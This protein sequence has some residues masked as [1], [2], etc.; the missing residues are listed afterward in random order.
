MIS[1]ADEKLTGKVAI[2]TALSQVRTSGLGE[3]P[4]ITG[5]PSV[6][7]DQTAVVMKAV[8]PRITLT[9]DP[10]KGTSEEDKD[11]S[12][13]A[14][15]PRL[16]AYKD[17][18]NYDIAVKNPDPD[19]TYRNITIEDLLP[20]EQV[21]PEKAS[22]VIYVDDDKDRAVKISKSPRASMKEGTDGKLTFT[23]G[24]FSEYVVIRE[25][26]SSVSNMGGADGP[27]EVSGKSDWLLWV[28]IPVAV[29]T[30][31]AVVVTVVLKKKK[32]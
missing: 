31:A 13:T 7:K 10:A 15:K 29:V 2:N 8:E 26:N 9:A 25:E 6:V 20:L 24:H 4:N 21:Q 16:M 22:V 11:L 1:P 14:E 12:T 5:Q 3:D 32:K 23:T 17:T 27:E 19:F 30:V 28:L 18:L